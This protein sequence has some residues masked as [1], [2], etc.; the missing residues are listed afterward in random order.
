[1]SEGQIIDYAQKILAINLVIETE[2]NG[3]GMN[4]VLRKGTQNK[5]P[6]STFFFDSVRHGKRIPKADTLY[7]LSNI[8]DIDVR[9]LFTPRDIKKAGEFLSLNPTEQRVVARILESQGDHG[10]F[11]K[12][13]PFRVYL[14]EP[15][16]SVSK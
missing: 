3:P 5:T 15:R 6:L 1:M 9:R 8:L 12:K 4:E 11:S 13:I 14:R 16:T 10:K 7:I 2:I